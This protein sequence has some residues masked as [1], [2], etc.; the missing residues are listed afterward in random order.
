MFITLTR[1]LIVCFILVILLILGATMGPTLYLFSDTMQKNN[2][3]RAF[4]GM[5]GLGH[6]IEMYQQDTLH[7]ASIFANNSMLIR[8]I[9]EKDSRKTLEVFRLMMTN[10]NLDLGT[11]TDD[12]GMVIARLHAPDRNGDNLTNQV[13]IKRALQGESISGIESQGK[14]QMAILASVPIRNS[15]GQL[16]GVIS[17]GYNLANNKIVDQAK[18][19]FKTDATIFLDDVRL[20]TTIIKDGQR[21]V[22][23]KLNQEIYKKVLGEGQKYFGKAEIIGEEYVTAYM[24]LLDFENKK[25]GVLFAGRKMEEAVKA[26]NKLIYTVAGVVLG[27][28]LLVILLAIIMAKR[29]VRPIKI[30]AKAARLVA[31]GDLSQYV[32][33]TSKDEVGIMASSFNYMV[34]QL[35]ELIGTLNTEIQE[36]KRIEEVVRQSEERYRMMA[37]NATDVIWTMDLSGRFTYI[38]PSVERLRGYT[39]KEALAQSIDQWLMPS[40][41]TVAL[42]KLKKVRELVA[43]G[44]KLGSQRI[45]LEVRCKDGSLVW[46]E[47]T[48][49]G[50]YNSEGQLLGIQGVDRDI[51][52]ERQL[53]RDIHRDVQ[54]AG[55]L[56]KALLPKDKEHEL[57]TIRTAYAPMREVSG[58]FYNYRFHSSGILRGYISDIT[59]HGIS[60]ALNSAAVRL[61]LDEALDKE[62][63]LEIVQEINSS[64][65]EHISDEIFVALLMFEFDFS[66]KIVTI[67]TGG[68]NHLLASTSKFNG[69]VTISG[70]LI[71]LFEPADLSLVRES[72]DSGDMF[73]FMTDGLMDLLKGQVPIQ[74]NDFEKCVES[75]Q[76]KTKIAA[77]KDDSSML[78]IK[79]Q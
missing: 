43:Q 41:A 14:G 77:K 42:R 22:G 13:N 3:D 56:Q 16:V 27:T 15:Q 67:V 29:I 39:V 35:K 58:D 50:I 66:K 69:L 33:V 75:L 59:G 31:I 64:L 48:C 30:I 79:I 70:G 72:I 76:G 54:L 20:S 8:A 78:C 25:I 7:H 18:T 71:G 38:S 65:V 63:T 61:I 51:T 4:Q 21:I 26:R 47:A 10:S 49:N 37:D 28:T 17:I 6:L 53:E 24:P 23:T 73:Y 5:E 11:V 68:I 74:V 52:D 34:S 9:E 32:A 2:E 55:R 19:M 36:R 1:K 44:E 57:F 46:V 40:S 60:A 62:L 45:E 12:Q